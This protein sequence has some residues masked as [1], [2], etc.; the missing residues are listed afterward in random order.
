M[1]RALNCRCSKND[2]D[3]AV[4]CSCSL[5]DIMEGVAIEDIPELV[6]TVGE[7][8]YIVFVIIISKKDEDGKSGKK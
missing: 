5:P 1:Y 6:K 2:D 7:D 4:F 8:K 3:K